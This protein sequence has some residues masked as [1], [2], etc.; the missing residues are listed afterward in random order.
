MIDF[1]PPTVCT[2]PSDHWVAEGSG[3]YA[4]GRDGRVKSEHVTYGYRCRC[5][6]WIPKAAADER[7]RL[8]RERT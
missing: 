7:R 2:H 6:A 4:M 1:P 3:S 8:E 5:G